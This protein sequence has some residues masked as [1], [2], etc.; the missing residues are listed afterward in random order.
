MRT[1]GH[2]VNPEPPMP[3]R[4][5]PDPQAAADRLEAAADQAIATC[6]GDARRAVKAFIVANES[7]STGWR[8]GTLKLFCS[9]VDS[10]FNAALF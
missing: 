8:F 10:Y 1:S 4:A 7:V 2:S 5:A 3:Q 9:L 6:D